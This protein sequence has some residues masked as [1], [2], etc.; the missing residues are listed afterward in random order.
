MAENRKAQNVTSDWWLGMP[1]TVEPKILEWQEKYS[2]RLEL[3][4][5]TQYTG[6]KIYALTVT[7]REV[8][9]EEKK[10]LLTTV[11]HG[12]EPAGT[13][14]IMNFINQLLTGEHLNGAETDLSV[15]AI[16]DEMLLTFIPIANPDGRSVRPLTVGTA[17][18]TMLA[19]F[20]IP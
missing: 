11:S 4:H 3:Q 1:H 20:S 5:T 16:L 13:A 18:F 6:H 19:S 2:D 17:R 10:K 12:H 7:N 15:D 9:A 14:A 8:P